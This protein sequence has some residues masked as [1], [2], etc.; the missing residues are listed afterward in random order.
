[1]YIDTHTGTQY[2]RHYFNNLRRL[3]YYWLLDETSIGLELERRCLGGDVTFLF[4][5][6]RSYRP[7]CSRETRRKLQA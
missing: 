1:M 7:L 3:R 2:I 4:T 6:P 5:N